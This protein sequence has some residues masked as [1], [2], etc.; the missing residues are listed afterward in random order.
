MTETVPEILEGLGND[1]RP[2]VMVGAD[3][4]VAT[5]VAG[6]LAAGPGLLDPSAAGRLAVAV[7]H[8]AQG[9]DFRVILDPAAF[10]NAYRARLASE[11][12]AAPW[13][14]GVQRLSDFGVP[15]FAAIAAPVLVG[16]TLVFHAEDTLLGVPYRVEADLAA[17]TPADG[18]YVPL[19]LEAMDDTETAVPPDEPGEALRALRARMATVPSRR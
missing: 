16:R 5:D 12:R 7:N 17:G 9:R 15:D 2:V 19:D 6:L 1:G 14:Q 10:E 8:L 13:R 4:V 18:A 11:D 3:A